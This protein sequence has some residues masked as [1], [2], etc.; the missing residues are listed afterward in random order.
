MPTNS[1]TQLQYLHATPLLRH[2]APPVPG[3]PY[4]STPVGG[5]MPTRANSSGL[6]SGSSTASRSSLRKISVSTEQE[7]VRWTAGV[8]CGRLRLQDHG[9]PQQMAG[10]EAAAVR[11]PNLLRQAAN[12]RVVHLAGV[13]L[14]PECSAAHNVSNAAAIT[15]CTDRRVLPNSCREAHSCR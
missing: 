8:A 9:L 14:Q 2:P 13:L 4:S 5:L 6:M 15:L 7:Q 3:G 10:S 11:S 12:A 1:A